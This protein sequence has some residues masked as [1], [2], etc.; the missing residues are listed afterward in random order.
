MKMFTDVMYINRAM[1]LLNF[2]FTARSLKGTNSSVYSTKQC[3][4][5]DQN[6]C[7]PHSLLGAVFTSQ[8]GQVHNTHHILIFTSVTDITNQLPNYFLRNPQ[9]VSDSPILLED[10]S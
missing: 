3:Q 2:H 7:F 4:N 10:Q 5:W 6:L 8:G 9:K 1:I